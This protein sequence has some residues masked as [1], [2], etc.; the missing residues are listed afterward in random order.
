LQNSDLSHSLDTKDTPL[1]K[2][3]KSSERLLHQRYPESVFFR[4]ISTRFIMSDVSNNGIRSSKTSYDFPC[5]YVLEPAQFANF[6][7]KLEKQISL[8]VD[9]KKKDEKWNEQEQETKFEIINEKNPEDFSR[10]PSMSNWRECTANLNM[11]YKKSDE[12]RSLHTSF[13]SYNTLPSIISE[14]YSNG[15]TNKQPFEE[16]EKIDDKVD[17]RNNYR[18]MKSNVTRIGARLTIPC[19]GRVQKS[20][21][22]R[23][24]KKLVA[25]VVLFYVWL[26]KKMASIVLYQT[27]EDSRSKFPK[28]TPHPPPRS[29]IDLHVLHAVE[30]HPPP[31]PPFP[32]LQSPAQ[33]I[34]PTTPNSRSIRMPSRKCSTPLLNR[35]A[36]T[37]EDLLK[38]PLK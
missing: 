5:R 32:S 11:K 23:S 16:T 28:N 20:P 22:K 12:T 33:P 24:F 36:I 2:K 9:L 38:V 27:L 30:G 26:I 15:C 37:V 18:E 35:P 7:T 21:R 14:E 3:S 29:A 17:D 34:V 1:K 13:L 6:K 8:P 19:S 31:P 10:S 25:K 4:I